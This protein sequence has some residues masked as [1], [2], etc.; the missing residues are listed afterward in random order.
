MIFQDA[1]FAWH[2]LKD[3]FT[4]QFNFIYC[5]YDEL[6]SDRGATSDSNY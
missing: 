4:I 6:E 1:C 2:W 5:L 3:N